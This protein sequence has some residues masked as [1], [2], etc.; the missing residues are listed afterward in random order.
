MAKRGAFKH[1]NGQVIRL[2]PRYEHGGLE[3][4]LRESDRAAVGSRYYTYLLVTTAT[5]CGED[6]Q[7]V[8]ACERG[9]AEVGF[10]TRDA[11]ER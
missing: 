4:T 6:E 10:M 5:A 2:S 3:L 7:D 8:W 9:A 11:V 1:V